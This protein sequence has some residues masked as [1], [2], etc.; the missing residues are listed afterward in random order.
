MESAATRAVHAD[1]AR[2]R[3]DCLEVLDHWE[4][5]GDWSQ[6]W[7]ALRYVVRLLVRVGA[8]EDAVA[9]HAALVAAGKPSPLDGARLT[10]LARDLGD[11]RYAAAA[12]T[13]SRLS[14]S[15]IVALA[16]AALTRRS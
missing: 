12:T 3:R 5:V 14:G 13:G 1:P 4:R 8:A 9:L 11:E 6:Q 15:A 16:R 2:A 7:I 10:G